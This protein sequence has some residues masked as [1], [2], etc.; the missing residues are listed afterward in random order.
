MFQELPGSAGGVLGVEVSGAYTMDEV[1]QFRRA[2]ETKLAQGH[3][4]VHLLVKI[5]QLDLAQVDMKAFFEDC[6]YSLKHLDQMG[7]VAIV[8]SGEIESRL[9]ELD[10]FIMGPRVQDMPETFFDAAQIEQAWQ[11]VRGEST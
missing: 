4:K 2:F 3:D 11:F 5:D 1:E 7:R 8:G 10:S 6:R 9:V